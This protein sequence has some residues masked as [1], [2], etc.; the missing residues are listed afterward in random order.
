M[1]AWL[2]FKPYAITYSSDHFERLYELAEELI[3]RDGAYV[4][5]CTGMP[6]YEASSF[7]FA[8]TKIF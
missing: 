5:H 1:V 4:C 2:G 8:T 6:H 3:R 7:P